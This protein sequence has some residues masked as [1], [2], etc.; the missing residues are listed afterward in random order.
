ME[1]GLWL[2][3]LQAVTEQ[4]V[5]DIIGRVPSERMSDV[6]KQFSLKL[7]KTNRERLLE[8]MKT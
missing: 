8:L 7:L 5:S 2:E 1:T 4:E 3:R 6:C